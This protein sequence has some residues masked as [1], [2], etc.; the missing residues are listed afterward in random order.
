MTPPPWVGALGTA[1][2]VGT[3]LSLAARWALVPDRA[4]RAI[5]AASPPIALVRRH[6]ERLA[7]SWAVAGPV[8]RWR[9]HRIRRARRAQLPEFVDGVVRSART[10]T[11]L[12][13]ALRDGAEVVGPPLLDD[14]E[15]VDRDV[16]IG[17][18]WTDALRRWSRE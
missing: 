8:A 15:R 14:V 6:G 16:A 1:L 13:I 2:A 18:P 5:G 9:E 12:P 7:R 4:D 11:S 17:L 10:G 3:S